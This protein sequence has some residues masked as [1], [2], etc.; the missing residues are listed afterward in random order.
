MQLH[1]ALND[2]AIERARL[3]A[4]GG[5]AIGREIRILQSS[6]ADVD[7]GEIGQT[8]IDAYLSDRLDAG[9]TVLSAR[10][11]LMTLRA[12]LRRAARLGHRLPVPTLVLPN[13]NKPRQRVL[14]VTEAQALLGAARDP[15]LHRFILLALATGARRG[16]L[17]ELQ[18][19]RIDLTKLLIDFNAPHSRAS[20]RKGRAV[21]PISAEIAAR[22]A[23]DRPASSDA[24]VIGL[25]VHQLMARFKVAR[26]TAKLGDDVTPHTLRHTAATTMVREVPLIIASRMLGHKSVA[27]T[28]RVYV[29]LSPEDLRP[30]SASL[31]SLLAPRP[32]NLISRIIAKIWPRL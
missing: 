29:H 4:D 31:N 11:E 19:C 14:S 16:A 25:T 17:L 13:E 26:E 1:E 24:L 30:A 3:V 28:E 7:V 2:Y 9:S 12:A 18:W 10:S 20:R 22:L 15:R 8:H 6:I 23:V 32:H 21:V 27:I 5:K